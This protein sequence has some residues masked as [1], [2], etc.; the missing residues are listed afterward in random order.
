MVYIKCISRGKAGYPC[1][2]LLDTSGGIAYELSKTCSSYLEVIMSNQADVIKFLGEESRFFSPDDSIFRVGF[3]IIK[4]DYNFYVPRFF[5]QNSRS[6]K[7]QQKCNFEYNLNSLILDYAI[8]LFYQIKKEGKVID[9][10]RSFLHKLGRNPLRNLDRISAKVIFENKEAEIEIE[11][12]KTVFKVKRFGDCLGIKIVGKH[13]RG[14]AAIEAIERFWLKDGSPSCPLSFVKSVASWF[15]IPTVDEGNGEIID[16]LW[17]FDKLRTYF[18]AISWND[19]PAESIIGAYKINHPIGVLVGNYYGI[20]IFAKLVHTEVSNV[21]DPR[22]SE[23][24]DFANV[25]KWRRGNVYVLSDS[26]YR[27]D[28]CDGLALA[29]TVKNS[30]PG[31]SDLIAVDFDNYQD[32]LDVKN[33]AAMIQMQL[34]C[35]MNSLQEEF[36]FKLKVK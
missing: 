32:Q 28:D 11:F 9:D 27:L 30:L 4:E 22:H 3:D 36:N 13:D 25:K 34:L 29:L 21:E 23:C 14:I 6:T 7:E 35:M 17:A 20:S 2:I 18:P 15:F 19:N 33:A 24:S 8:E 16:F 31:G 5:L 10:E 12:V 1:F 26:K